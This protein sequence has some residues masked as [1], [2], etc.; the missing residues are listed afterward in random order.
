MALPKP[1]R[2]E[3]STT[4]PSSGKKIKY[5]PFSVREEKILMLAAESQDKDEMT[6]AVINVLSNCVTSPS[7]FKVEELALFDIEYL[8]LKTRAK[9]VGEKIKLTITDPD[10]PTFT[11]PHEINIDKIGVERTEGHSDLIQID[12]E[13]SV[14]MK[15]PDIT[16]FS[17]GINTN[18]V[19]ENTNLISRCISQIIVGEE[20]FNRSEMSDKEI[21]EWMDG[22]TMD[23]YGKIS[24]FFD[25]MPK[26]KHTITLKNTNTGKNFTLHLEGLA[27]FF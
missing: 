13:T 5:Q 1:I 22:L 23:K 15:Y 24:E 12:E 6:N 27:D 14:K 3:Y 25:T 20:V 9:S 4:I 2:P 21:G 7:D 8:F 11:T 16:F 10:D 19:E 26:L 18:N 17:E